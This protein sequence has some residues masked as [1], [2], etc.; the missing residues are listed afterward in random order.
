[1]KALRWLEGLAVVFS[2][3]YTILISYGHIWCWLF[4]GLGVLLYLYIC[5]EKRL[6]AEAFL[7]VFYLVTTLYG[8]LTWGEGLQDKPSE[9]PLSWHALFILLGLGLVYLVGRLLH[10]HTAAAQPYVDS[11]TTLFGM[12]ATLL[13]IALYPSNWL[14][15]IVIDGVSV[16][17]YYRRRLYLTS[18][19]FA[20]Y[21]LLSLNGYWQWLQ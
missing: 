1:M 10:R 18:G 2:L 3:L 19:L 20:L 13:M 11:F 7:Q 17:L 16:Y 14:Y 15:W 21:T 12:G 8:F 4:S 9:L 5:Y 6:F